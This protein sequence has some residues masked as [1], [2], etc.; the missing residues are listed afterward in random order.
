MSKTDLYNANICSNLLKSV[1]FK[2]KKEITDYHKKLILKSDKE[3]LKKDSG[4]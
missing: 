3:Y 4:N 2:I 1:I